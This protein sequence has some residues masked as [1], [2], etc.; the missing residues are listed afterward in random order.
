MLLN[1]K[2]AENKMA[3][4]SKTV[5]RACD[6]LIRRVRFENASFD[7]PRSIQSYSDGVR[8]ATQLFTETWIVPLLE[9][10]RDGRTEILREIESYD[11]LR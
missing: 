8:Q 2:G 3:N 4:Q 11:T 7:D 1:I 6:R 5:Q 9:A 10:I